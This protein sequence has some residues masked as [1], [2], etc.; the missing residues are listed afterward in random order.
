[1]RL[2]KNE[3]VN[4]KL[5]K[6]ELQK[7][8]FKNINFDNCQFHQCDFTECEFKRCKFTDCEFIKCNLS[9]IKIPF[10]NF[11]NT[12]FED[13][14]VVGINWAQAQWPLIK[15]ASPIVFYRCNMNFSSFM[16]LSLSEIVIEDCKAEEVDF[17]ETNLSGANLAYTDFNKSQFVHCD[18][19]K[20]D[21]TEATGYNI[22]PN[23]NKIKQAKF[24]FPEV[25]AL[26]NHFDIEINNSH[27]YGQ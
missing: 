1:M 14:K 15:L 19:T 9:N 26:L 13:S 23:Q 20:T 27:E 10:S 8:V 2:G 24:S 11:T 6:L 16:G 5:N 7:H 22:D 18:L 4:E 12:A 17:R 21:F 3:Y 25:I